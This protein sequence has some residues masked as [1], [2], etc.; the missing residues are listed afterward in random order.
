LRRAQS[1]E[2]REAGREP[3]SQDEATCYNWAVG[4]TGNDPFALQKQA[5]QQAAQAEAATAQEIEHFKKA[6]SACL[7]A[8]DYMVKF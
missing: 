6:F 7:E 1:G 2:S 3:Q 5:Q 4:Q 8:K